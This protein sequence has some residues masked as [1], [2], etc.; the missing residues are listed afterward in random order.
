MGNPRED[1]PVLQGSGSKRRARGPGHRF[2]FI[3]V[4]A[5]IGR[6]DARHGV[7]MPTQSNNGLGGQGA[8]LRLELQGTDVVQPGGEHAP[9]DGDCGR[10]G[11]RG[12]ASLHG[13]RPS[14]PRRKR[15]TR[16]ASQGG[17][18]ATRAAVPH[19]NSAAQV[20]TD[21]GGL[22]RVVGRGRALGASG[23]GPRYARWPDNLAHSHPLHVA[24][25]DETGGPVGTEP[26]VVDALDGDYRVCD[27]PRDNEVIVDGLM[28]RGHGWGDDLTAHDVQDIGGTHLLRREVPIPASHPWAA[29]RAQ[30]SGEH[31]QQR[32]VTL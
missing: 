17:K 11:V 10:T 5:S 25:Q 28:A 14:E 20:A 9:V 7:P 6:S 3:V 31:L 18:L 23:Q 26:S 19:I 22:A 2:A 30:R 24:A 16:Q 12:W 27:A 15:A 13:G 4:G 32:K 21:G 8:V 29:K 1:L